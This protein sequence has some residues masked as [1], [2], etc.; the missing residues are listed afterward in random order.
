MGG[1]GRTL[2]D[3][4]EVVQGEPVVL[5]GPQALLVELQLAQALALLVARGAGVL[6][7]V[8]ASPRAVVAQRA[9][10]H[11]RLGAPLN[12]LLLLQVLQRERER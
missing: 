2:L 5:R 7:Q 12:A 8:E 9:V 1:A 10:V 4:E 11:A 3:V 6:H